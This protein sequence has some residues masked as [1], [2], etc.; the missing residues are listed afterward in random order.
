[1]WQPT[2][3]VE[4][5]ASIKKKNPIPILLEPFSHEH[6]SCRGQN[7]VIVDAV[8]RVFTQTQGRGVLVMDRGG[9]A[10]SLLD[11]WLDKKYRFVVRLR[12][13]RDL[14][15]YYQAFGGLTDSKLSHFFGLNF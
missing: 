15:Q 6:P 7:P 9:D 4:L 5:Y 12:G 14:E 11:D 10:R 13:D 2:R 3:L 8:D 1:M